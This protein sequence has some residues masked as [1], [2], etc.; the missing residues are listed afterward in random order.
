MPYQP[1]G[2]PV[3]LPPPVYPA[4]GYMAGPQPRQAMPQYAA[5]LEIDSEGGHRS[6]NRSTRQIPMGPMPMP[7]P[8][9]M[10][11]MGRVPG[12]MPMNPAVPGRAY[13][14]PYMGPMSPMVP[15]APMAPMS[16]MMPMMPQAGPGIPI[17][18]GE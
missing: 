13:Y 14:P 10:P 1:V 2:M 11:M 16:P 15:M 6:Q 3:P 18:T 9:P 7:M 5:D 17:S 4:P 8:G 12:P